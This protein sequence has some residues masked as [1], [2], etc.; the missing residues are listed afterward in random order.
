MLKMVSNKYEAVVVVLMDIKWYFVI[1]IQF[2][3]LFDWRLKLEMFS[4][5]WWL[6]DVKW[7]CQTVNVMEL[8]IVVC[9]RFLCQRYS[10]A[11]L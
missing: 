4:S 3:P 6:S 8:V 2:M 10:V 7:W 9:V 1:M 5:V 11:L